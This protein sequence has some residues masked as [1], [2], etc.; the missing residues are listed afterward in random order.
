MTAGPAGATSGRPYFFLSYAHP[1]GPGR[2]D[3][4]PDK[5]VRDFFQ[6]LSEEVARL[7]K[8]S[9]GLPIGFADWQIRAGDYWR[10]ELGQV[11]ATCGVFVALYAQD[12]FERPMC[13]Q[14]WAAFHRRE[15]IHRAYIK[16]DKRAI[17]PVMWRRMDDENMPPA[18]RR[19][20][21]WL[22]E[23]GEMYRKRGMRELVMRR[24]REEIAQAY[25]TALTAFAEHIVQVADN[26]PLRPTDGG[27]LEL[28]PDENAFDGQWNRNDPRPLRFVVVA[29]VLGKLPPGA[30][31][32]MYGNSP[33]QWRPYWPADDTPIAETAAALGE[34]DGYHPMVEFLGGCPDLRDG[35]AP[36]APTVLI[37]DP[38]AAHD[39]E[40]DEL[41]RA[42]DRLS[43]DKPWVRL[44]IPWDKN[45]S[46]GGHQVADLENGLQRVLD[47]TRAHCRMENPEAVAGL[48]SVA[49][50][51]ERLPG[52]IAAAERGYF[53]R[54]LTY[55]PQGEGARLP[56]L[57]GGVPGS[58]APNGKDAGEGDRD[59]RRD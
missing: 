49:A 1:Q 50:F 46:G 42:F 59:A 3:K 28:N 25:Q 34:A 22:H 53:R 23:A 51:G 44:V 37:V 2:R 33:E 8:V 21:Y 32:Q 54:T 20:H 40:L 9:P 58:A 39:Q 5:P 55:A 35:Q 29:P 43:H 57:G 45:N 4:P 12:Y 41:L 17:V 26:N 36:T 24:N 56:R 52:V 11:L 14:E 31:P 19:L 15:L 30:N 10:R 38:W 47:R 16:E 18:A 6:D 13:G 7:A 48:P 27:V